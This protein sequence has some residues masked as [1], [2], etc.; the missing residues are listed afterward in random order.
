[1]MVHLNDLKKPL[2]TNKKGI[3]FRASHRVICVSA[4]SSLSLAARSKRSLK[5]KQLISREWIGLDS[6][7]GTTKEVEATEV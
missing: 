5:T 4:L 7:S 3:D 1:M 6:F 2:K